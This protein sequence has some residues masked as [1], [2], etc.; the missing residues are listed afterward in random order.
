MST[1]ASP[2]RVAVVSAASWAFCYV[3]SLALARFVRDK[4]RELGRAASI[5][6]AAI[7]GPGVVSWVAA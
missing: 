5:Q 2:F 4:Q 3:D 1:A 7:T 6:R